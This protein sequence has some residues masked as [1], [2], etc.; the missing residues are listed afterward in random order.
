MDEWGEK[1]KDNRLSGK[2]ETNKG[3]KQMLSKP[4]DNK[5]ATRLPTCQKSAYKCDAPI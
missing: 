5:Q 2:G 4:E 1:E 3:F